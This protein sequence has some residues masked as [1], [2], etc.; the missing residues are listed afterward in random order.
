MSIEYVIDTKDEII[1][2]H[3]SSRPVLEDYQSSFPAALR[4]IEPAGITRWLLVLEYSEPSP[5]EKN[6]GFNQFV[7]QEIYR[8]VSRMAV[9]CPLQ[10]HVR[11][12]DVLEPLINQD[13][14]VSIFTTFEEA[15]RWL[16]E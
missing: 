9:V 8:Y 12:R 5:D 3:F 7:A 2:F 16:L 10:D 14:Q 15:K 1:I 6:L 13:K 11:L 4:E